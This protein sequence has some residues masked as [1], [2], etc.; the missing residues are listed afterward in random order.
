MDSIKFVLGPSN[1]CLKFGFPMFMG[2]KK[3]HV[4]IALTLDDTG[5]SSFE[6]GILTGIFLSLLAPLDI[7]SKFGL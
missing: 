5:G 2:A 3:R 4:L 7:C 1:L 6:F